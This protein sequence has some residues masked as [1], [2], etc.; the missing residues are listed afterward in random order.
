MKKLGLILCAASALFGQE[1][2][3]RG[4]PSHASA[5]YRGPEGVGYGRG[6][7]TL[8]GFLS[9]NWQRGFQPFLDVR[10]H[11]FDSGRTAANVG[12]GG[13]F[14]VFGNWAAGANLF[15]D[16]RDAKRLRVHQLGPG[17]EL[18]S[19]FIDFRLNGYF[20]IANVK[21][22]E[23]L[24]FDRFTGVGSQLIA[25]RQFT[26][27]PAN[28][29][30]EVGA[31]LGPFLDPYLSVGPYYLFRRSID[32]VGCAGVWGGLARLG[33][34]VFDGISIG[35]EISYD[36]EYKTRG[37]GFVSLS[38]PLGPNTIRR[39]GSKWSRWYASPECDDRAVL[40]RV[41]T[42]DVVRQEI[43]PI[44][45]KAQ[46]FRFDLAC[47]FVD[48]NAPA[49][50]NGTFEFP[51]NDLSTALAVMPCQ[52][53][54]VLGGTFTGQFTPNAG[55]PLLGA[56]CD[57]EIPTIEGITIPLPPLNT[58]YPVLTNPGGTII[59]DVAFGSVDVVIRGFELRNSDSQIVLI[60]FGGSSTVNISCNRFTQAG[61]ATLNI[62]TL[63]STQPSSIF[64]DDNEFEFVDPTGSDNIELRSENISVTNNFFTSVP[65]TQTSD[66]DIRVLGDTGI[67]TGNVAR[68]LNSSPGF[69]IREFAP[70]GHTT[71]VIANNDMEVNVPAPNPVF[72][73]ESDMPLA[74]T[75]IVDNRIINTLG[76]TAVELTN[77]F[78][79]DDV[80]Y[81]R[82]VSGVDDA[83]I[84]TNSVAGP[85]VCVSID[86]NF[87]SSYDFVAGPGSE[88]N[89]NE[90]L[91]AATAGNIGTI[92]T[93]GTINFGTG[94][95][96][97]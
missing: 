84:F 24:T 77:G 55:C 28:V 51:F 69:Q 46:E 68:G 19:P 52:C 88:I 5:R 23:D 82:N 26:A 30:F 14:N 11:M 85:T 62:Q 75:R 44:C 70:F 15:Y 17:L 1:N 53:I 64:I 36:K 50:G 76:T 90:T 20:P 93:S 97:P 33:L 37:N 87:A 16:F 67:F 45:S 56:G 2:C 10:G 6:Y 29:A 18:L 54:Y 13:R 71:L 83:V 43:V 66:L 41:M 65:G 94:C 12:M 49:G 86:G 35:G 91:G 78:G 73:I 81:L 3:L 79:S 89:V 27:A 63:A 61:G 31:P 59:S 47:L 21:K 9:P 58:S 4:T 25:T 60:A 96:P 72:L 48:G 42:K 8:E 34:Q 57:Q 74:T 32:N 92:T 40:Q 80:I 95:T 22:L 39:H 38:Y 7:T